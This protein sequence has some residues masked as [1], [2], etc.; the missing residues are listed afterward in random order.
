M[1]DPGLTQ[2][3][4]LIDTIASAEPAQTIDASL[5]RDLLRM[6]ERELV[7]VARRAHRHGYTKTVALIHAAFL[8]RHR[9]RVAWLATSLRSRCA[10]AQ[11]T[12]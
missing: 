11:T 12:T 4:T 1:S 7:Q 9:P 3:Q 8:R 6:P 2:A 5:A 10:F